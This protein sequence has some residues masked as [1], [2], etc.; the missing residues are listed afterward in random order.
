[1]WESLGR[2]SVNDCPSLPVPPGVPFE[3]WSS[4]EFDRPRRLGLVFLFG[5]WCWVVLLAVLV[6]FFFRPFTYSRDSSAPGEFQSTRDWLCTYRVLHLDGR[7]MSLGGVCLGVVGLGFGVLL[8]VLCSVLV[9]L[10]FGCPFRALLTLHLGKF[11]QRV[12]EW[13]SFSARADDYAL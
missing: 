5:C 4:L 9:G 7:K 8:V 2:E 1:M 3:A 11:E 12:S 13:L 10:L 6:A